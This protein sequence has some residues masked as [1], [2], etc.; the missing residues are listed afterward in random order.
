MKK[1][2]KSSDR[3]PLILRGARQ[4]GKT[5]LLQEFGKTNYKSVAYVS[6]EN[7]ERVKGLFDL[8]FDAKRIIDGIELATNT[9][10]TPGETLVILD[11]IQECPKAITA[12][13]YF[14]EDAPAYHIAVAGRLLGMTLHE[15]VSFPVGKV[16]FLDIH[17]LDFSEFLI[18]TG[19]DKLAEAISKHDF[20]S[21]LPF[22][23]QIVDCLKTY[24]ITGGMPAVVKNYLDEGNLLGTR[25][26]QNDIIQAYENDFSKHAPKNVL[27]RIQEIFNI[28][29]AQLAK[30][31][32][33]FIFRMIREGA[34]AKDYE[35]ALIWLED[36]GIVKRITRVNKA[37][38]PLSVYADKDIFKLYMVDIGLLG[39]KVGLAPQTVLDGNELFIEFK[40]AMAEQFV[41]QELYSTGILPFYYAKD[42]SKGEIDFITDKNGVLV[43]IEVKSSKNTTSAS[44]KNLL[45]HNTSI[46]CG[47]KLSLLPY[48]DNGNIKNLPL[49]C[50][51]AI[52]DLPF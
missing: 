10:I 44:L 2:K 31:N 1:W 45:E 13:K 51:A 8:D 29:S 15:Q 41:F 18:A 43:P 22:H 23:E 24:L 9:K 21:I 25:R 12:L 4:V 37:H 26:I 16:N 47:I 20:T 40:G 5:W 28:L 30:E 39:A 3:K 33:K 17:P 52:G 7:N 32:K 36:A 19:K 46:E 38:L 6:L 27:P 42:N 34:R 14:S 35:M 48:K 49:Y 11:E 50:A